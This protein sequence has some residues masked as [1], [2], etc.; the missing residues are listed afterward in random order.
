M[1]R[2]KQ[3]N[4]ATK[5]SMI[6]TT[7]QT[8]GN[9]ATYNHDTI[10]Q[11]GLTISKLNSITHDIHEIEQ[12]IKASQAQTITQP[13]QTVSAGTCPTPEHLSTKTTRQ[14]EYDPTVTSLLTSPPAMSPTIAHHDSIIIYSF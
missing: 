4:S 3:E 14:K 1:K 10:L 8:S 12:L 13:S 5:Q 6:A 11:S 2:R 7:G 9:Q